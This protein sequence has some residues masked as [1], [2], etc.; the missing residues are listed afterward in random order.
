[1]SRNFS[2]RELFAKNTTQKPIHL[3][4]SAVVSNITKKCWGFTMFAIRL[5][6]SLRWAIRKFQ[7]DKTFERRD[8]VPSNEYLLFQPLL[9]PSISLY[10]PHRNWISVCTTLHSKHYLRWKTAKWQI[11]YELVLS[12]FVFMLPWNVRVSLFSFQRLFS[13]FLKNSSVIVHWFGEDRNKLINFGGV[14]EDWSWR[15]C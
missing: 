4:H 5:L 8:L 14:N 7:V 10:V 9:R 2:V 6:F 3:A 12:S 1:M 15:Q 11:Y 13:C